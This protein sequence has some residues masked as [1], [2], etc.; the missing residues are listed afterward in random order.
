MSNKPTYIGSLTPLR[1]I[2]A[3]LVVF[4]HYHGFLKLLAPKGMSG[5]IDKSYLMVD[6][7]F[8]LSG[9]VMFH[10]YGNY[11][12][13][14][15]SFKR[16]YPPNKLLG[17]M[18]DPSAIITNLTLTQALGM[19]AE[20]TWNSPAW[21]ICVEW[22]MYVIFPVL[23]IVFA[24]TRYWSRWLMLPIIG[25]IYWLL[26][27][28]FHPIDMEVRAEIWGFT[29]TEIDAK[30]GS[31]NVYT[32]SSIL[33]CFAGF[34]LGMVV[35]EWFINGWGRAWMS[36][37]WLLLASWVGLLTCWQLEL[38]VDPIAIIFFVPILLATAYSEGRA[39]RIM[40]KKIFNYLG[41]ISY[42]IYLVHLPII[43]SIIT[44]QVIRHHAN[45]RDVDTGLPLDQVV[46]DAATQVP[47]IIEE[48]NYLIAWA[49]LGVLLILTVAVASFTYKFIEKPMRKVLKTKLTRS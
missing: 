44:L 34:L 13:E 47:A 12:N 28:Y 35:Y 38:I 11:F 31:I 9:F 27:D 37:G 30:Y 25:L 49:G 39:F 26:M 6:F 22:W 43:L 32:G 20:A 3:L 10:A 23:L 15:L 19:H 5:I 29:Q 16:F 21:S 24:Q 48:P 2:A 18:F 8:I 4:Y 45:G 40:N 36:N 46:S 17:F 41:D 14:Q 33:R 7:F 1:G 42:S